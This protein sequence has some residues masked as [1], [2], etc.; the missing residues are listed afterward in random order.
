[1]RRFEYVLTFVRPAGVKDDAPAYAP[2]LKASTLLTPAGPVTRMVSQPGARAVLRTTATVGP[3]GKL[4]FETGTVDFGGGATL[5]YAT[6]GTGVLGDCADPAYKAGTVMWRVTGGTGAFAGAT[7]TITSNFLLGFD[8]GK[9]A[10]TSELID[11][12]FGV[13]FLP[14]AKPAGRKRA[15]R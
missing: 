10:L 7:G 1:M 8:A 12:H 15:T 6:I 13:V 5:A 3:D 9:S 2:G 4:F 11:H 14:A